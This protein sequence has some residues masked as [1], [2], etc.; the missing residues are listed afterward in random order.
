MDDLRTLQFDVCTSD[1]LMLRALL[2]RWEPR[3]D[4]SAE[5]RKIVEDARALLE[6]RE[7]WLA[8]HGDDSSGPESA[9]EA[10]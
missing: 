6:T 5:V 2:E 10:P 7:A 9:Q 8:K 1:I 3:I 4:E